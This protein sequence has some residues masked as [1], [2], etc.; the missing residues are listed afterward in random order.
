M[1]ETIRLLLVED[2]P[3]DAR[4]I[5]EYLKDVP[6]MNVELGVVDTLEKAQKKL[7]EGNIDLVLLNL[8]LPDSTG[9][10]TVDEVIAHYPSVPVVVLTGL[11]DNRR[12][13]EAIHRGAQDYLVKDLINTDV[14]AR[15]IRYSIHR[16]QSRMEI[17]KSELKYRS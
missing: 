9:F 15:S 16:K 3:G 11:S 4:L 2:N 10:D 5:Q 7:E 6:L 14:L 8:G 12:A 17:E 13:M 1:S